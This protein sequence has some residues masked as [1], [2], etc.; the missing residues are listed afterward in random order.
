[1]NNYV[2]DVIA[3]IQVNSLLDMLVRGKDEGKG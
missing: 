1:M 3:H 2:P